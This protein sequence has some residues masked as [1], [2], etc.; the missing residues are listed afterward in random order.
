M[1]WQHKQ[2]NMVALHFH[3]PIQCFPLLTIPVILLV[4]AILVIF[5]AIMIY[6]TNG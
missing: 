4:L 1:G 5:L 2:H 6:Q 3:E